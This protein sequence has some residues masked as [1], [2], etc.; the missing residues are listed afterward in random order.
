MGEEYMDVEPAKD[1]GD[2]VIC[3]VLLP[4][5]HLH[6]GAPDRCELSL[7]VDHNELIEESEVVTRVPAMPHSQEHQ[8]RDLTDI[9]IIQEP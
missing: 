9:L 1:G 5:G 6:T 2:G 7:E 4:P 8:G 3:G